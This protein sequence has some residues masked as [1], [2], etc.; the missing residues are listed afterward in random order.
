MQGDLAG[1]E[2]RRYASKSIVELFPGA[3]ADDGA[4]TFG[5]ILR[6]AHERT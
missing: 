5:P 4:K 2:V 6:P 1:D 3:R